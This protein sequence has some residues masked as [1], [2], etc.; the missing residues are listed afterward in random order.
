VRGFLVLPIVALIG[1]ASASSDGAATQVGEVQGGKIDSLTTHNY[2]VGIAN[3]LGAVC[4][5]TLIAPNLVLTARHCVIPPTDGDI[6]TCADKFP[7]NT[8]P[9]MLTVTTD[10]VIRGAK[11]VYQAVDITTPT[12]S[13]FCGNDIALIR[14]AKN[15]PAEEAQPAI[16]VV[17]F[18]ISD[19][20]R[21]L[22]GQ[23]TALGYGITAPNAADPGTRHVRQDIDIICVP[24][25]ADYDCTKTVY[26]SMI[27]QDREFIT[28]GYVCS[29]DSG[30]GAFDQ[31]SFSTSGTP[32]VLGALS[33]GPSDDTHCL[34]AIYSRTDAHK[35][36]IIAAAKTAATEGGYDAPDWVNGVAPAAV[37]PKVG[38][39]TCEGNTCTTTDAN[40]P[41][42]PTT[43]A[44]V[45]STSGCS[46]APGQRSSSTFGVLLGLALTLAARR[47]R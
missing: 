34:A 32:F 25:D 12:D 15:I 18:A 30:G 19:K 13:S 23:V 44:V 43:T 29:G 3:K 9:A 46:T 38:S 4:S 42:A 27:D 33:R 41:A 45:T 21:G 20:T 8:T 5:G 40:E 11:N 10:P 24:G 31:N 6:V 26:A 36:L 37:A 47:R 39:T 1:C 16:P 35:D 2:A 14:L 7:A 17:N 28:Q 22:D